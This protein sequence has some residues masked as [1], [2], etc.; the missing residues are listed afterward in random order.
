M[1]PCT[2]ASAQGQ[3]PQPRQIMDS[4]NI[5][6]MAPSGVCSGA[7]SGAVSGACSDFGSEC[8]DDDDEDGAEACAELIEQIQAGG[9]ARAA[10]MDALH[11]SIDELSFEASACRVVQMAFEYGDEDTVV[12]MANELKGHMIAAMKDPHANHVVQKMIDFLP[13]SRT[14]FVIEEIRG[15]AVEIARHRHGCRALCR[16]V[17]RQS[18]ASMVGIIDELLPEIAE[19]SR[20]TYAHYVVEAILDN[21]SPDHLRTIAMALRSNLGRNAKHRTGTH[22]IEKALL[23]CEADDCDAMMLELFHDASAII[24]LVESQ[25]GCHVAK[26]LLRKPGSHVRQALGFLEEAKPFLEKTKYG[27]RLLEEFRKLDV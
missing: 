3:R 27:R 17:Q 23:R 7:L 11:G 1:Q 2:K 26:S 18:H 19:M 14:A 12:D 5:S 24:S 20:H 4:S 8:G 25:F 6:T 15:C 16:L 22:V 21:G 13:P 9:V 10:A